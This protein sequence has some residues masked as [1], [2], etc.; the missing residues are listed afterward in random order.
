MQCITLNQMCDHTT[1]H[2]EN[3]SENK[4]QQMLKGYKNTF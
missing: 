3:G 1:N 4:I 2:N